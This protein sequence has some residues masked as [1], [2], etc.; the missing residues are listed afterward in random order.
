M[1]EHEIR[2]IVAE[3]VAAKLD[4][5][6]M[7]V[8]TTAQAGTEPKAFSMDTFRAAIPECGPPVPKLQFSRHATRL[9]SREPQTYDRQLLVE[10][11][12]KHRVPAAFR[13]DG[14]DGE[15][16]VTHPDFLKQR[17]QIAAIH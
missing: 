2:R 9:P 15:V 11:V 3:Q 6:A 12:G 14:F 17:V 7:S 4:A 8:F 10:R 1:S 16:I 5:M 13:F